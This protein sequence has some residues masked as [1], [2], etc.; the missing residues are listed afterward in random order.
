MLFGTQRLLLAPSTV[1]LAE[2][3]CRSSEEFARLLT[4]PVPD[5]WPPQL[6]DASSQAYNRDQLRE[7]PDHAGW[8]CWYFLLRD[9]SKPTALVGCGGFHGPP[10]DA[11]TIE[12]GYS[13]VNSHRR[14]G[15]ATE[16]VAGIIN[17]ALHQ[18]RD[19]AVK[20]II[21]ETLPNLIP[22]IGVLRKLDFTGPVQGSEPGVIRFERLIKPA[23]F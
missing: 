17:W 2:A 9:Q 19:H 15:Y 3:E 20:R 11:G 13:I 5:D 21:A 8:W 1:A 10:D 14:R 4:V 12:V 23:N 6:N 22:S 18:Q 16:A 7:N